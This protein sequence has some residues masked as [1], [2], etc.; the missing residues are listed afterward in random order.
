MLNRKAYARAM[1]LIRQGKIDNSSSWSFSTEDGNAILGDPPDWDAYALFFL[2]REPGADPESKAAYKY[3]YGKGGKVYRSALVAIRQRAGQ[4]DESA[5]YEAAGK[6]LAVVDGKVEGRMG[7]VAEMPQG[8]NVPAEFQVFPAGVVEIQGE[9]PFTVD[10][11]AIDAVIRKFEERGIDMV[12]DFEHQT[13]GG[14]WSSPDGTAPAAGWI[15][16][17]V[18]RGEAGLWAVAEW[19]DRARQ[20]LAN[21]EYRYFSPVFLVSKGD[22]RRLVELLRV[23]LT[24][25][26]LLNWIR[27]I[28]AAQKTTAPTGAK[29][30]WMDRLKALLKAL[31]LAE[32][33][34]AE[35]AISE[36]AKLKTPPAPVI[37]KGVVEALGLAESATESEIVATIHAIKQRPDLTAEVAGLKKRLA[38]RDRDDLVAKAIKDGKITPAQKEWAEGYALVDPEGFRLFTAKAPQ[39]V[40]TD[41]VEIAPD[42]A[43]DGPVLDETQ[44]AVNKQF[45]I[46]DAV[47]A[48]HNPRDAG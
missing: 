26:P 32:D 13:E 36:I 39:V 9:K 18:N 30:A 12:I 5:I 44:R 29:E 35:Q 2:L 24:N 47:F 33:A 37:A 45:G 11:A 6:L 21:R 46:D 7:F 42:K 10:Q 22:H 20:Y 8:A 41:R 19:T 23:A 16:R 15:K 40:P 14:E 31:G 3:P 28:A 1:A 27:P 4:Q 25:A 38:E 43:K 34:S 17:L 48:K